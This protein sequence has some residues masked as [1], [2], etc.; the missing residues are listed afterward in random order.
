MQLLKGVLIILILGIYGYTA[1]VIGRD[2]LDFFTPFLTSI[3]AVNWSGQFN[4][5][6]MSYLILSAL[7]VAWRHCFTT[8]GLVFAGLSAVL[9]FV[10][11]A[12]YLLVQAMG[13][14]TVRE[15][16]LGNADN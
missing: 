8:R 15:L 9:G 12:P 1:G 11:F 16:V 14:N 4:L 7:W 5:D 2:G 13:V 6:F 3:F 10:F